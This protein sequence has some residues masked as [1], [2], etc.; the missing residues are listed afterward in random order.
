VDLHQ[1]GTGLEPVKCGRHQHGVDAP[2][3]ERDRL[4]GGG[5]HVGLR[6][7]RLEHP[8]ISASGSTAIT[9]P[10]RGRRPGGQLARPGG[11]IDRRRFGRQSE[12]RGEPLQRP[13]G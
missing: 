6:L 12:P 1:G 5:A 13:G 7:R 11:K 3:L 10:T 2:D 8:R 4:G 9:R